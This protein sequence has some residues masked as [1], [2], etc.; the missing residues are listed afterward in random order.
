MILLAQDNKI[1]SGA[2]NIWNSFKSFKLECNVGFISLMLLV[3]VL[4]GMTMSL[5][6]IVIHKIFE[7][8]SSFPLK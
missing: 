6:T 5:G 4:K 2:E 8:N 7:A 3:S 1:F